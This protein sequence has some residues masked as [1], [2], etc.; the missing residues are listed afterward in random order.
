MGLWAEPPAVGKK[1]GISAP[2]QRVPAAEQRMH[3]PGQKNGILQE[4]KH[5]I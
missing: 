2:V 5:E 3:C 1:K 4:K